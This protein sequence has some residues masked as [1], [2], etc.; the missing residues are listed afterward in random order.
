MPNRPVRLPDPTVQSE[1]PLFTSGAGRPKPGLWAVLAHGCETP[2]TPAVQRW[3]AC[4][5][6]V[7]I[8][9]GTLTFVMMQPMRTTFL[10]AAGSPAVLQMANPKEAPPGGTPPKPGYSY[11][12]VEPQGRAP[13]T[14]GRVWLAGCPREDDTST[15]DLEH[16]DGSCVAATATAVR[17]VLAETIK[18]EKPQTAVWVAPIR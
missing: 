10:V 1:R 5:M 9:D 14:R 18:R 11:L 3:P 2:T 12:A 15:P 7:W 6:P 4:A 17:A 13:Y 8:E 16:G